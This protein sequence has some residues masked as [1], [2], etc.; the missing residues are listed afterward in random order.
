MYRSFELRID[1]EVLRDEINRKYAN[2]GKNLIASEK[3]SIETLIE[4]P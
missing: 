3:K 1:K 2:V 4:L